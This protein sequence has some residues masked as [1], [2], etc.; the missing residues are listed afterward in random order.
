M[1]I[2]STKIK[3]MS[4]LDEEIGTLDFIVPDLVINELKQIAS[5]NN[6]KK[7]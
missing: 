5:S 3:N 1:H 2:A 6:K 7:V 4:H